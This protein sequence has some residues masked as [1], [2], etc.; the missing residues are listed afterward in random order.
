MAYYAGDAEVQSAGGESLE[1]V[2]VWLRELRT[3][4][5]LPSQPKG[6][7]TP[8]GS[9]TFGGW[10]ADWRS[11]AL[12]VALRLP[13][14]RGGSILLTQATAIPAYSL[15]ADAAAPQSAAFQGNG[16]SLEGTKP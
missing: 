14:G 2:R 16:W 4:S 13:D 7:M 6:R 11:G 15:A 9:E 5:T 10:F 12:T 1:R 8:L 3:F